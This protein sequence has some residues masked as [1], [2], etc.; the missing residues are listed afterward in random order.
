MLKK[1]MMR[2]PL[3]PARRGLQAGIGALI[4]MGYLAKRADGAK[5][6]ALMMMVAQI[7]EV[8]AETVGLN[9][10]VNKSS[11]LVTH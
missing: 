4:I 3:K 11:A 8:Q 7:T 1:H 10:Q 5:T 2:L 9:F 6:L